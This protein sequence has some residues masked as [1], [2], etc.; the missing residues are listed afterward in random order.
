MKLKI[1]LAL[2]FTAGI[3]VFIA[4]KDVN[5]LSNPSAKVAAWDQRC[6]TAGNIVDPAATPLG[7]KLNFVTIRC[8]NSS[9]TVTAL[10]GG[11]TLLDN[12]LAGYPI[13]SATGAVDSAL[14]MEVTNGS[15]YCR[16]VGATARLQCIGGAK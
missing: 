10:M 1:I 14:S 6:T 3:A 8:Q 4:E 12:T 13:S 5:A 9:T 11:K 16:G 7:I 2:M 15:L